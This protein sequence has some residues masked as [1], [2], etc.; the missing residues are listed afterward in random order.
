MTG[1]IEIDGQKYVE[2]PKFYSLIVPIA[3]NGQRV[4]T[5]LVLPSVALFW[6]KTLTRDVIAGGASV[7]RRF[8]FRFG[9]TDGGIW[10]ISGGVGSTNDYIIDTLIFGDGQFPFVLVPHI[11]YSPAANITIEVVDISNNAPYDIHMGFGGSD[12]LPV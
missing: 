6:L 3:N 11:I 1:V 8:G 5:R 12:L 2:R 9:N 7:S 10:Y 4:S